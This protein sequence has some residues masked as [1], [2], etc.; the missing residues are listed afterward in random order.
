MG[1]DFADDDYQYLPSFM[2]IIMSVFRTSIGDIQAYDYGAWKDK[3]TDETT[4][5]EETGKDNKDF[6]RA[7]P[8]AITIIWFIWYFNIFFM[9]IILA[10]FL[11]SEVGVTF[12]NVKNLGNVF[13][14]REKANFNLLI[15]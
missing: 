3:K 13:L 2:R 7:Q 12:E 10:N 1:A 6:L 8:Y 11:I 9:V 14:N 15:F 5:L 4:L